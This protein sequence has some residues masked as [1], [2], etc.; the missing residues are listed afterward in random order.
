MQ[1][2][3]ELGWLH[4][5]YLRKIGSP[6]KANAAIGATVLSV[7]DAV[8][9][10]SAG[11]TVD[12]NGDKLDYLTRDVDADTITLVNPLAAAGEED[13]V[14]VVWDTLRGRAATELLA[15][16]EIVNTDADDDPITCSVTEGLAT[17][18]DVGSRDGRGELVVVEGVSGRWRLVDV[19]GVG[20][21]VLKGSL[22]DDAADDMTITGS[23]V[24]TNNTGERVVMR[25]DG[26]SGVVE[27]FG[28]VAGEV[29]AKLDARVESPFG[30][31]LTIS[32]PKSSEAADAAELILHDE[33]A[34]SVAYLLAETTKT[35]A[36][37]V[38][39]REL[40]VNP[41]QM[42][43]LRRGLSSAR[44]VPNASWDTIEWSQAIATNRFT[45]SSGVATPPNRLALY[46]V[47]A[48]VEFVQNA[49]GRRGLRILVD[50]VSFGAGV[51]VPAVSSAE[52]CLTVTAIVPVP[53]N[54]GE[55]NQPPIKVQAF[56]NSGAGIDIT[57][58]SK[59]S[60]HALG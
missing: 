20:T 40:Y 34:D 32:G 39:G 3:Q 9:F 25:P 47:V 36:D 15:E 2:N 41:S 31:R 28:G 45:Y 52:T 21:R 49:S 5:V 27:F 54:L 51:L 4:D 58:A 33:D 22:D 29:P 7:H 1:D 46:I 30:N 24:Q 13:D 16:V 55:P 6:L 56:Q 17:Q 53:T 10:S 18:L 35:D 26:N 11:G 23:T 57:T 44:N 12:L 42:P 50:G 14:V 48:S 19:L 60:I 38:V 37:L 43:Q 8:D 59:F